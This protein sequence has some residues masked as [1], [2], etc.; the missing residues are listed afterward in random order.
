MKFFH[1]SVIGVLLSVLAPAGAEAG[2]RIDCNTAECAAWQSGR[3][4]RPGSPTSCIIEITAPTFG[5]KVG[6][7]VRDARGVSRWGAPRIQNVGPGVVVY[8]IGC[9]WLESPTAEVYICVEGARGQF[10]SKR[11]HSAGSLD[12]ALRTRRLEMCLK[13]TECPKYVAR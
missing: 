6:L 10:S 11:D 1:L 13:G 12:A 4:A 3:G 2:K 9:G 5:G 8:R 7:D